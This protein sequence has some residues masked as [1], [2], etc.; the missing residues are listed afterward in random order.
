VEGKCLDVI[1]VVVAR[2]LPLRI[3]VGVVKHK[4]ERGESPNNDAHR[5]EIVDAQR[6]AF[7]ISAIYGNGG[8]FVPARGR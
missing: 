6:R 5:S 2:F 8:P 7:L 3:D 4:A 1:A